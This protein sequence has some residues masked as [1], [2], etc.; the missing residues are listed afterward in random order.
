GLR[1]NIQSPSWR[2]TT[3][4]IEPNASPCFG[5]P[6]VRGPFFHLERLF[7]EGRFEARSKGICIATPVP[8]ERRTL[9][10]FQFRVKFFAQRPTFACHVRLAPNLRKSSPAK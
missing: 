5:L 3:I 4:G 10:A 1:F 7:Y 6:A 9:P 2:R 8:L